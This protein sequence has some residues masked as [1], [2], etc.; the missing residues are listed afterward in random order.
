MMGLC[1]VLNKIGAILIV[2]TVLV[3]SLYQFTREGY[4]GLDFHTATIP[5]VGY[6]VNREI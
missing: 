5:H 3:D 6:A 1:D 2:L 4:R